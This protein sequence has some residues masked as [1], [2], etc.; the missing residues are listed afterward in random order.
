MMDYLFSRISAID[1]SADKIMIGPISLKVIQSQFMISGRASE[2]AVE[3]G[4]GIRQRR[5]GRCA[6]GQEAASGSPREFVAEY[7]NY[8]AQKYAIVDAVSEVVLGEARRL[9]QK[10]RTTARPGACTLTHRTR[11]DRRKE[12]TIRDLRGAQ[13]PPG[14]QSYPT[15]RE[16]SP[17]PW[18]NAL[19]TPATVVLQAKARGSGR[20]VAAIE[21]P[22]LVE[23]QQRC[24]L[25]NDELPCSAAI[26]F[27]IG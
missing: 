17:Y 23:Q 20:L 3:A 15:S 10:Q 21:H 27:T 16:V 25:R 12:A 11:V 9:R 5:L 24:V 1:P 26:A 6:A 8:Q 13:P 7:W 22:R 19:R 2:A 4:G 14:A 18:R